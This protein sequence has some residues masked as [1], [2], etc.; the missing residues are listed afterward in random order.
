MSADKY[1]EKYMEDNEEVFP[2]SSIEAVVAKIKSGSRAYASLQEYVIALIKAL[3]KN[4]DGMISFEEFSSG[5][6]Q[7]Q[8]FVTDHE[9]HTLVRKFDHN[10]DGKISMEE[11]YNTI[12]A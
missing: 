4:G 12:A 7:M 6:K 1:T 3:D 2:E 10:G 9:T 5:L 11:F 8:I